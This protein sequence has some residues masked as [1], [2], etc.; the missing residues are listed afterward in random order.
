MVADRPKYPLKNS[1]RGP[2]GAAYCKIAITAWMMSFGTRPNQA[3]SR[4]QY[5][6]VTR[7]HFCYSDRDERRVTRPSLLWVWTR[8]SH[9]RFLS[10]QTAELGAVTI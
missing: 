10:V 8:R 5:G 4:P 9:C 2:Y 3:R 1:A 7:Q 6:E